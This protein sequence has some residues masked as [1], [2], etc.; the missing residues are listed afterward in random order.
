MAFFYVLFRSTDRL[1]VF[2]DN[3]AIKLFTDVMRVY[4]CYNCKKHIEKVI[5][6]TT[7]SPC[8]NRPG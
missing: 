4:F 3:S 6:Y 2:F 8:Q 5:H 7:S 1:T